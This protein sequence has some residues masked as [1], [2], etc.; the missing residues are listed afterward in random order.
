LCKLVRFSL[1]VWTCKCL[2]IFVRFGVLS[3]TI[4]HL[5]QKHVPH[6]KTSSPSFP[7]ALPVHFLTTLGGLRRWSP[8]VVLQTAMSYDRGPEW[9]SGIG[10]DRKRKPLRPARNLNFGG[11]SRHQVF[12]KLSPQTPGPPK[13]RPTVRKTS[14]RRSLLLFFVIQRLRHMPPIPPPLPAPPPSAIL[15]I[16]Q[17]PNRPQMLL[18][19][20]KVARGRWDGC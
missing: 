20:I 15:S 19:A 5:S 4:L 1:K 6:R 13:A 16:K 3:G 7:P 12:A 8:I 11:M 10:V 18:Y 9:M 14:A 17:H 2:F